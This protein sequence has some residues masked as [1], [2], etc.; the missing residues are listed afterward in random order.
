LTK[1]LYFDNIRYSLKFELFNN[2]LRSPFTQKRKEEQM[3]TNTR[4]N[5]SGA[6]IMTLV[7]GLLLLAHRSDERGTAYIASAAIKEVRIISTNPDPQGFS[8]E[9]DFTGF[10]ITLID[11]VPCGQY[12]T[13]TLRVSATQH[14]GL[15][16]IFIVAGNP[17]SKYL[18]RDL[19]ISTDDGKNFYVLS[20]ATAELLK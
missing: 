13:K 9:N 19:K 11:E 5:I 15:S 8:L 17:Q 10:E 18:L 3:N 14:T 12:K 4:F 16:L 7:L 6:L 20:V 2:G 1:G